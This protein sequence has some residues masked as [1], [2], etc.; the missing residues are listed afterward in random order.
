MQLVIPRPVLPARTAAAA[1]S[2]GRPVRGE[3]A[4]RRRLRR[5]RPRRAARPGCACP[6]RVRAPVIG[7]AKTTFR[8]TTRAPSGSTRGN[9]AGPQSVTAAGMP[10]HEAGIWSATLQAA[11]PSAAPTPSPRA[12]SSR[13]EAEVHAEPWRCIKIRSRRSLRRRGRDCLPC[14]ELLITARRPADMRRFLILLRELGS[15][16]ERGSLC[17]RRG[18]GSGRRGGPSHTRG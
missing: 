13:L 5:P 11:A 16:A 17:A 14:E 8:T 15:G 18:A 9:P 12:R 2:T 10:R 3:P 6:R 4:D 7:I 1:R